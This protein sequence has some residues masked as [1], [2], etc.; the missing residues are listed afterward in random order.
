M[1]KPRTKQDDAEPPNLV[2]IHSGLRDVG[3]RTPLLDDAHDEF[4]RRR[5]PDTVEVGVE[6]AA[7]HVRH[8][9]VRAL[10]LG[11]AWIKP[12][13]RLLDGILGGWAIAARE[14][15][16]SAQQR[17]DV[18]AYELVE[19]HAV[20]IRERVS[21]YRRLARCGAHVLKTHRAAGCVASHHGGQ[22]LG[23]GE[24]PRIERL[25]DNGALDRAQA[26]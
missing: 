25:P 19:V 26:S 17:R 24:R 13:Q 10:H 12:S 21:R 2:A 11:P 1:S 18:R 20:R 3:G 9:I 7:P 22:R 6:Q 15:V 23:Q 16:S 5:G 8:R 4:M 14:Q